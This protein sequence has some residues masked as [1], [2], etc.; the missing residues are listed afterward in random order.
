MIMY[1][2]DYICEKVAK[3]LYVKFILNII[4]QY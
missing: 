2:V 3:C 4:Q 1:S